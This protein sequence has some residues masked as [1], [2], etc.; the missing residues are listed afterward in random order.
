MQPATG[1]QLVVHIIVLAMRSQLPA[2][3]QVIWVKVMLS[4]PQVVS[5]AVPDG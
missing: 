2:P 4:A 1:S 3:S 5:Q